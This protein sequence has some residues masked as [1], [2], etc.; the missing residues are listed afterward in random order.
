MNLWKEKQFSALS[1]TVVVV[2]NG[3]G[4]PSLN[5][6][7]SWEGNVWIQTS[8]TSLMSYP[9]RGGK[10]GYVQTLVCIL[11]GWVKCFA[12]FQ[13]T[14]LGQMIFRI[15]TDSFFFFFAHLYRHIVSLIWYNLSKAY[16]IVYSWFSYI[17]YDILYFKSLIMSCEKIEITAISRYLWEKK[18]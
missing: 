4:V 9:A 13:P 6:E 15:F 2:G 1:V 16:W 12:I 17:T 3:I 14:R 8:S 7:R 5:T 11:L 18:D 10:V